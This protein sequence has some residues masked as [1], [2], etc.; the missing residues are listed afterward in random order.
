[1][2]LHEFRL[3]LNKLIISCLALAIICISRLRLYANI[4]A[5]YG[6]SELNY[7]IECLSVSVGHLPV[8]HHSGARSAAY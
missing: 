5:D 2:L 4:A 1:M 8:Y 6:V 7:P 3:D